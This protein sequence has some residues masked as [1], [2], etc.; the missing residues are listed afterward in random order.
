VYGTGPVFR[1]SAMP[2]DRV[3][4]RV[5]GIRVRFMVSK[6]RVRVRVSRSMISRVRLRVR[7][8]G[9]SE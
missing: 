4:V 5:R 1:R 6:V 7:A 2:K 3:T 8:S 9:R